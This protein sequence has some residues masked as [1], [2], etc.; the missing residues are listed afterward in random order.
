M[1][2]D[3]HTEMSLYRDIGNLVDNDFDYEDDDLFYTSEKIRKN[4]E[5]E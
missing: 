5:E 2:L 4:K 3:L 1:D